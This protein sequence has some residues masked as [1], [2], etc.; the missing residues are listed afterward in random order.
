VEVISAAGQY[1]EPDASGASYEEH[2]RRPDLSLGT[3]SLRVGAVDT[4][5]PHDEDEVYVVTAG[6]GRFTSGAETIDVTAGSVFFVPAHEVHRFH[7]VTEDLAVLVFFGPA[8]GT[9]AT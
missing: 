2:L 8:E 6:S 7:D 1:A 3:Y 9:R 4:Q 5:D